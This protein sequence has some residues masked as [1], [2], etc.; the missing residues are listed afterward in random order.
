M[1]PDQLSQSVADVAAMCMCLGVSLYWSWMFCFFW[2]ICPSEQTEPTTFILTLHGSD[3]RPR[4]AHSECY[5][6]NPGQF[7]Y[8]RTESKKKKKQHMEPHMAWRC[9]QYARLLCSKAQ[10]YITAVSRWC[11]QQQNVKFYGSYIKTSSLQFKTNFF[12]GAMREIGPWN[13][14]KLPTNI[15]D[16]PEN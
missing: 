6:G 10:F 2:L 14:Y 15:S 11:F 12:T 3:D 7:I 13:C 16:M 5:H 1:E 8:G 9:R 4:C